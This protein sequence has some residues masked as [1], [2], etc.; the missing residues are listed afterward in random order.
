MTAGR[1]RRKLRAAPYV[2]PP[3][4]PPLADVIRDL[5]EGQRNLNRL[6]DEIGS[7]LRKIE[8]AILARRPTGYPVEVPFPP[9]GKLG[10]SGR[11]GRWRLVVREDEETCTDLF[12]MPALCR[13]DACHVVGKLVRKMGLIE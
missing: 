7:K 6:D 12:N 10:W 9:W 11:R 5:A 4:A 8:R 3:D 13:V 1:S 2:P